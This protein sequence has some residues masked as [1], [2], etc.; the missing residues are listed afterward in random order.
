MR[1]NSTG[2][3]LQDRDRHLLK[4]L[5]VMRVIDREQAK[6]VAGFGS[7]TRANRRLLLLTRAGFLRRFF[8]GTVGGAR[9]ALYAL[10]MKGALLVDVPYRGPRRAT[11]QTLA[12]DLFTAHQL[13][14]N[15]LY[16]RLGEASAFHDRVHVADSFLTAIRPATES[17]SAIVH[18]AGHDAKQRFSPRKRD[19][20]PDGAW[21]S[22]I[23]TAL[24]S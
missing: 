14:I 20:P 22:A 18:R 12:G 8:L 11:D 17:V 9:K 6:C 3:I 4:E 2:M 24:R 21:T 1:G 15:E 7:T 10:S 16:C 5:A 23:R 13:R 19:R